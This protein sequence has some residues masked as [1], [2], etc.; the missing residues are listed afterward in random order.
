MSVFFLFSCTGFYKCLIRLGCK[1]KQTIK[2]LER[3]VGEGRREPATESKN[4]QNGE[5]FTVFGVSGGSA[6]ELCD[7]GTT[8]RTWPTQAG[9]RFL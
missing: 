1:K 9:A 8:M 7:R 6:N 4:T 2:K 5:L 3:V